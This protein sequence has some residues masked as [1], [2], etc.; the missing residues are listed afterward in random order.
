MRQW[1]VGLRPRM[2]R[3]GLWFG[4][5]FA[6]GGATALAAEAPVEPAS[7]EPAAITPAPSATAPPEGRAAAPAIDT[8]HQ[9]LTLLADFGLTADD[10]ARF[11]DGRAATGD[12]RLD[13]EWPTL[14]RLL[15]LA[16]E[17]LSPLLVHRWRQEL[18]D[19][20]DVLAN[21]AAHRGRLI[22]VQGRALRVSAET[23]PDPWF[24]RLELP[25]YY[26]VEVEIGPDRLPAVVYAAEVPR[27]WPLDTQL[28]DREDEPGADISFSGL[29]LKLDVAEG[30][31]PRPVLVARRIAWHPPGLLGALEFDAGLLADVVSG[32][33]LVAGDSEAFYQLLARVERT[34]VET[35]WREGLSR[36]SA[37]GLFPRRAAT[38][39]LRQPD[40]ERG[41]LFSL[42]GTARRVVYVRVEDPELIERYGFDHYYEIGL[43]PNDTDGNPVIFC[44]RELPPGMPIGE[45]VW[46]PVRLAGFFFKNWSYQQ[47]DNPFEDEPP[48]PSGMVARRVAPLFIG[49]APRLIEPEPGLPPWVG[50]VFSGLFVLFVAAM[51]VLVWW[52]QRGDERFR[53]RTLAPQFF[54]ERDTSLDELGLPS[55]SGPDFSGLP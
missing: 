10:W 21:P 49:R 41:Q 11:V 32:T 8:R 17:K 34:G 53:R 31:L 29:F 25:V 38:G 20:P 42:T 2:A 16:R 9:V 26:R 35:L 39:D 36:P 48:L 23:P 45:Q 40:A 43:F 30:D 18:V 7:D 12:E 37:R 3:A 28:A 27:N 6:I 14:L 1:L 44:V 55:Q 51:G 13:D 24:E 22:G 50:L 46:A 15:Y 52:Q 4:L 33:P 19:W 47:Q 54:A 5:F